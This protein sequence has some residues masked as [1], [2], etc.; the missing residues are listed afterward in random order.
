MPKAYVIRAS[1]IAAEHERVGSSR[2]KFEVERVVEMRDA[3]LAALGQRDVHVRVLAV[4]VEHNVV[5]AALADTFNI[6]AARGGEIQPGNCFA[7]EVV[8]VGGDVQRF[9]TGDV[10]LS[11]AN[12]ENDPFGYPLRA[13]AY[14][15][16]NSLGC[17][18]EEI[19]VS[20]RQLAPAPLEC[21]LT[22]WQ[23]AAAPLR[24]ASAHHLWRR[25]EA[26]FRAKVP[27][28]KLARLN[29]LAFGG[30]VSEF[31]LMLAR[32][33]G[34]RAFYCAA[35]PKRR[36]RLEKMGIETLDQ[37]EFGRFERP[38]DVRAFGRTARRRTDGAGMHVVCD[39]FRGPVFAAG[40][41]VLSR[42]GVDVSSGWQL[43]RDVTYNS[44]ALSLRQ[45]TIDHA[46]FETVDGCA[47]SLS[48]LGTVFRPLVHDEIYPFEA[49]PRALSEL[50]RNTLDGIPVVRVAG[51]LPESV[52]AISPGA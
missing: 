49:L 4:S 16:P 43:A 44:A 48:L 31:F 41:A 47:T 32:S 11:C 26:I 6:V 52:R 39:M 15:Q 19:V 50:H 42:Q 37:S 30:G 36:E 12:P 45:I 51:R 18:A 7:G 25:G 21:G 2:E 38:E 33:E 24:A 28:E 1:A 3:P 34:H 8:A 13:W 35:N 20:E 46:H 9:R 5:H 27:R 17:Y 14:D 10:V 23:L 29:V 40:L 22:L